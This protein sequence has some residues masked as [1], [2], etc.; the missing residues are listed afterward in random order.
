MMGVGVAVLAILRLLHQT[1][2]KMQR[3]APVPR[4][5]RRQVIEDARRRGHG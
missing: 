3:A 5:P 2:C 1:L 4:G